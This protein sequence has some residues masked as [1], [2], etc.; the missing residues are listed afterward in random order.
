MVVRSQDAMISAATR[1]GLSSGNQIN[2][3]TLYQMSAGRA[4]IGVYEHDGNDG[5]TVEHQS[6]QL[7]PPAMGSSDRGVR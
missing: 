4:S 7:Q 6:G 5:G 3:D 2:Y 1:P